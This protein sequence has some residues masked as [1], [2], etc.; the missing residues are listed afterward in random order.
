LNELVARTPYEVMLIAEGE[1]HQVRLSNDGG[2]TWVPVVLPGAGAEDAAPLVRGLQMLPDGSL[3]GMVQGAMAWSLLAPHAT[4]W[5]AIPTSA[6]GASFSQADSATVVGDRLWWLEQAS[7]SGQQGAG[8]V[9]AA[10][11]LV[12]DVACDGPHAPAAPASPET[13]AN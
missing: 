4:D 8:A 1:P 10:S 9:T 11:T 3:I 5:C 6:L 13:A 12:A 7:T 2:Q